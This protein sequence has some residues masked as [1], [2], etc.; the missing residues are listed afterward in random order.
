MRRFTYL[1]SETAWTPFSIPRAWHEFERGPSHI[2]WKSV[3]GL[4][5]IVSV[6]NVDGD[7]W[8]HASCSY[9]TELPKWKDLQQVKE[10][11]FGPEKQVVQVLAPRSEYVNHHPFCLN[12]YG[13][14]DDRRIVPDFREPGGSL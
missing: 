6:E 3:H 7:Q 8:I 11:L 13:R 10:A 9:S 2:A 1:L 5:V 4:R 12:L 14:V